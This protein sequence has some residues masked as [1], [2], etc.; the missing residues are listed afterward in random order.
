MRIS[1]IKARRAASN[2]VT[3]CKNVFRQ[4]LVWLTLAC[5]TPAFAG[6][7]SAW[8]ETVP[9]GYELS[10][11]GG[12]ERVA[13]LQGSSNL[14][15]TRFYLYRGALV[16]EYDPSTASGPRSKTIP[17]EDKR[18]YI[19]RGGDIQTFSDEDAFQ[20]AIASQRL[21]PFWPRWHDHEFGLRGWTMIIAFMLPLPFVLPALWLICLISLFTRWRWQPRFRKGFVVL[22]PCL[23]GGILLLTTFPQSF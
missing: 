20:Q 2:R 1:T 10:H 6:G 17:A 12:E 21:S 15:L 14:L 23:L 7:L 11:S 19:V 4:L 16:A 8:T 5:F 3:I 13:V 22:Y 18:H 9:G